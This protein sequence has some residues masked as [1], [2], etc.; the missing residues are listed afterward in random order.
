[1]SI[2]PFV[3][4]EQIRACDP[5]KLKEYL[6][7]GKPIVT[8]GFPAV[9]RYDSH[10]FIADTAAQFINQLDSA[11]ALSESQ[12]MDLEQA[13]QHIASQHSWQSKASI[14][15]SDMRLLNR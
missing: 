6:A 15:V 2:L 3:T 8:T 12:L 9:N 1:V 10:L 5:L 14:V 11:L 4:N 7:A 13:Q